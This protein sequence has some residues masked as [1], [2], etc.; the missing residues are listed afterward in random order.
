MST[1]QFR[2]QCPVPQQRL[3]SDG[4]TYCV[5]CGK[6]VVTVESKPMSEKSKITRAWS[7]FPGH[8]L[9]SPHGHGAEVSGFD[10]PSAE[11]F[12]RQ[13]GEAITRAKE[14]PFER[15]W[16]SLDCDAPGMRLLRFNG[17]GVAL[18]RYE[19]EKLFNEIRN[20]K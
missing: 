19:A 11:E 6:W 16:E 10:L 15:W 17:K 20:A 4:E 18:A 7:D 9:I 1:E 2:C 13:L 14:T 12:H 5:R 8:I 3:T